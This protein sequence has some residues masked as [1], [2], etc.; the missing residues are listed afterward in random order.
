M[1]KSKRSSN[2]RKPATRRRASTERTFDEW[3]VQVA[4]PLQREI[5]GVF[6]AAVGAASLL[7]LSGIAG[8][9]IGHSWTQV[10]QQLLGW[11]SWVVSVTAVLAG[12]HMALRS[13]GRPWR[14][15][16]GQVIGF[17]I[18]FAASL[19]ITHL[20]SA[21]EEQAALA[22]A[23]AGKGGGYIGWALSMPIVEGLGRMVAW[24]ALSGAWL[25]GAGL[26]LRVSHTDVQE[27]ATDL[28]RKLHSWSDGIRKE[29][30]TSSAKPPGKAP[31]G[32]RRAKPARSKP[33]RPP[34]FFV[35]LRAFRSCPL[36][37]SFQSISAFS[38][39]S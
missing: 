39:C 30:E 26:M 18:V 1:S 28:S 5:A 11:G 29:E 3:L 32:G 38:T 19:A 7:A 37:M 34:H 13:I 9:N 22:L 27:W 24:M 35:A 36:T 6:V 21:T 4:T 8:G 23:A 2:K 20:A 17:E 12:V 14:I 15:R 10:L 31:S 33:D 25:L 16:M